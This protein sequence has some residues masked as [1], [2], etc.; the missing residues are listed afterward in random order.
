MYAR[1]G[2]VPARRPSSPPLY[3]NRRN[4]STLLDYES[5]T[6]SYTTDSEDDHR[7]ARAKIIPKVAVKP[8]MIEFES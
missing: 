8:F 6:D 7:R 1:Q 2:T 4:R 5:S 3:A